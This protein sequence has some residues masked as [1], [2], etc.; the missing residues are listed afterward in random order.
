MNKKDLKALENIT[1]KL[2]ELNIMTKNKT[3]EYFYDRLEMNIL[4][5]FIEDIDYNINK[6]SKRLKKK[7]SF[8]DWNIIE[9]ERYY[10][11]LVGKSMKLSKVWELAS[12][13]YEQFYQSIL[14]ILESELPE[15]FYLICKSWQD[16]LNCK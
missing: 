6:I 8:I 4:I 9:K 7:Y 16:E 11:E 14:G 1:L 10:D 15:Y 13:L 3:A 2:L 12:T 5:E